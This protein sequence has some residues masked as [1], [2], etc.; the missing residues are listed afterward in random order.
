MDSNANL[1]SGPIVDGFDALGGQQVAIAIDPIDAV[2]APR[3]LFCFREERVYSS[4]ASQVIAPVPK[5]PFL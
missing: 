4:H 5:L 2:F 1:T 3:N